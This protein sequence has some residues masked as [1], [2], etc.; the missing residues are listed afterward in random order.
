MREPAFRALDVFD[1]V[2]RM[3]EYAQQQVQGQQPAEQETP[4]QK[5]RRLAEAGNEAQ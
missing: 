5:A 2:A 4:A 3:K 1:K